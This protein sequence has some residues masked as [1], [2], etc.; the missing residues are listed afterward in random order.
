MELARGSYPLAEGIEK[1][2]LEIRSTE[3]LRSFLSELEGIYP[4]KAIELIRKKFKSRL[5]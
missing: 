3:E 2:V 5:K 4:R 1:K